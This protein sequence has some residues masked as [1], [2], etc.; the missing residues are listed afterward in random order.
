MGRK[1]RRAA[2]HHL[3][4]TH[5][6]ELEHQASPTSFSEISQSLA[7]FSA[8]LASSESVFSKDP[9]LSDHDQ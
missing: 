6:C 7:A 3:D 9:L 8:S 4:S 5:M 2:H 1:K